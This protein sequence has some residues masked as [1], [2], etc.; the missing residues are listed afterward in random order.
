MKNQKIAQT[1]KDQTGRDT[2]MVRTDKT[3]R[4]LMNA[5][6][7]S[8]W[9]VE[10]W[11]PKYVKNL[12]KLLSYGFPIKKIGDYEKR[13]TYGAIVTGKKDYSGN[14]LLLL[15]QGEIKFTGLDLNGAKQIKKN[16]PWDIERAKVKV[17][18]IVLARSGIGGVGKNKITLVDK[19]I[20]AVVDSFVDLL[21]L[22]GEQINLFYIIVFWK[23]CFGW[24]Q[25]ERIINGV[26]TVNI[27]FDEI[28]GIKI[29]V[30]P[31]KIQKNIEFEYKKMS[32]YHDKAMESKK[33]SNEVE[34]KNNIEIAEKMLKDLIAKTE[35]VIR[36]ERKDVI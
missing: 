9:N 12:E 3:V 20:N 4:D 34:Y 6:P 27:S 17:G 35:A 18:S 23:T 30:L 14:D 26:G 24:L 5:E 16:T 11:N 7:S 31:D 28:R 19:P 36:G 22:D 25:I 10:Y 29:P 2:I 32:V 15:N 1:T 21:D 8:R 33:K 13:L